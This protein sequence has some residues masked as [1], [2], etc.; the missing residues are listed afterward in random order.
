VWGVPGRATRQVVVWPDEATAEAGPAR[1]ERRAGRL[2]WRAARAD[3]GLV[4]GRQPDG[5]AAPARLG[6]ARSKAR[7][8][9]RLVDVKVDPKKAT[10]T[11]ALN[12]K[13]LRI[14]LR[15]EGRYLLR[16]NL[17]GRD[18]AQLRQFYIQLTE[19]EAA[20]KNLKDDL[21]LQL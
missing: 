13:K 16:T 21:V 19:I 20:F 12:R 4:A 1:R 11:Y 17:T 9:W 2:G 5:V 10:F 7:A 14:A 3:Q 6:A 8:A 15:R 18:P